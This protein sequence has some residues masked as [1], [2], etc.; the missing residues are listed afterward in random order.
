MREWAPRTDVMTVVLVN[1]GWQLST[2]NYVVWL[3]T[4]TVSS[5][6]TTKQ[7]YQVGLHNADGV[8]PIKQHQLSPSELC[9]KCN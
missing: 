9:R 8:H 4:V 5:D 3:F 2:V 1:S 7:T 6:W